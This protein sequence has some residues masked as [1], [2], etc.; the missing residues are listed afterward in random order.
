MKTNNKHQVIVNEQDMI[1][2]LYEGKQV[3]DIVV[4]DTGWVTQYKH[5]AQLFDIQTTMSVEMESNLT[6]E[7]YVS[8]CLSNDSWGMPDKYKQTDMLSYL[9]DKCT[10]DEQRERV[11]VEYIEFEKRNMIPVLKFLKY[12][13]DTLR[14]H[15]LVWG[16]GRGSSVASYILFLL[17]VHKI[18]SLKYSI[19]IKEFLK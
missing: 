10:N 12:F 17:N 19:P 5:V 7:E 16:V 11:A 6:P 13:I 3:H 2:F 4:D 8:D 15:K 18:D 14:E 9:I 1:N